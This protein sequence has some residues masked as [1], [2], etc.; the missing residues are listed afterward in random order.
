MSAPISEFNDMSVVLVVSR[1]G[2]GV[3]WDTDGCLPLGGYNSFHTLF[4]KL[5]SS[6]IQESISNHHE[7]KYRCSLCYL[8]A[9]L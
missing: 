3:S 1:L 9:L 8:G 7:S 5:S 2:A 6:K 4:S